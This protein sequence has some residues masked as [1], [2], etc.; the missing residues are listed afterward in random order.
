MVWV[1]NE[2]LQTTEI[3]HDFGR[4]YTLHIQLP[5]HDP[6]AEL[7]GVDVFR[8]TWWP[9]KLTR[10]SYPLPWYLTRHK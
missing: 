1:G 9:Y 3:L 6:L 2:L 7:I 5:V 10:T 8:T 4:T